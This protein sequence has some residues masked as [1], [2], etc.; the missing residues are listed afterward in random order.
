MKEKREQM[1][2]N[3]R[4]DEGIN[5]HPLPRNKRNDNNP[6]IKGPSPLTFEIFQFGIFFKFHH[7]VYVYMYMYIKFHFIIE[8]QYNMYYI[9]YYIYIIEL[10]Y[11]HVLIL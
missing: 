11:N 2:D 1:R 9:L 6:F 10:Q 8:L 3:K 4:R 7:F 5:G